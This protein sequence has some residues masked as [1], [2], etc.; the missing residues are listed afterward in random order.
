[1][2]LVICHV[3]LNFIECNYNTN[4]HLFDSSFPEK[5]IAFVHMYLIIYLMLI[6]FIHLTCSVDDV[7]LSVSWGLVLCVL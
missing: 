3:N 5:N 2:A 6:K 1:M 7:L 4:S